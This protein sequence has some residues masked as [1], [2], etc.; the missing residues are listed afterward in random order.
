MVTEALAPQ[1]FTFFLPLIQTY[2]AISMGMLIMSILA[3]VATNKLGGEDMFKE[4]PFIVIIGFLIFISLCWP[5]IL[6]NV[7]LRNKK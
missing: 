3:V 2:L 4:I 7:L 6:F 5:M 1:S